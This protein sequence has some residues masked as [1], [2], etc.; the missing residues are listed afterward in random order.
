MTH[1]TSLFSCA[2]NTE[3]LLAAYFFLCLEV[4]KAFLSLA[5]NHGQVCRSILYTHAYPTR[6]APP[7]WQA[8]CWRSLALHSCY[9]CAILFILKKKPKKKQPCTPLTYSMSLSIFASPQDYSWSVGRTASDQLRTKQ[10]IKI[11]FGELFVLSTCSW[12]FPVLEGKGVMLTVWHHLCPSGRKT[13]KKL[14][15]ESCFC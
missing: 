1:Y 15:A 3:A 6:P 7:V 11:K 2:D 5:L 4:F 13:H 12:I 14:Y 9:F 8:C 10:R